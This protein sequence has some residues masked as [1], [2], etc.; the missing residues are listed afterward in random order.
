MATI[1]FVVPRF[2]TNLWF[3][4][5]ALLDAG[6]RVEIAAAGVAAG[7]D[8]SH[9]VPREIGP[10]PTA[11]ELADL[12]GRTDPDLAIVRAK[13]R[14][15]ERV[16]AA[17]RGCGVPVLRYD[18]RPVGRK[19]SF[20]R[21][22]RIAL[23]R[24]PR[25]RITPVPGLDG[26]ASPGRDAVYLPFPVAALPHSAIPDRGD[27]EE[28]RILAVGKLSQPRKNLPLLISA[29][30]D[31]ASTGRRFTLTIAGSS[32]L[33][34]SGASRADH[35][36][37]VAAARTTPWLDLRA[38]VPFASMPDLYAAH[39]VCVLP[40]VE[41]P[42]GS[43][44]LEGMAYGTIP[45]ISTKAGT[46]GL[47]DHGKTGLR[48]DVTQEGALR[49][50]MRRL[51]DDADLRAKLSAGARRYAETELS[52]ARYVARIEALLPRGR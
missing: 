1:L 30:R 15:R 51:L 22:L 13:G 14:V 46:A 26:G 39:D 47:I 9:V 7:E 49:D 35:A 27:G 25:R 6:H 2:H 10:D 31:L 17:A 50:A 34:A 4:A 45:V 24:W 44:P 38:D 28:V 42:L 33:L 40:S 36:E 29:L 41:E 20:R 23:G 48:V 12:F 16:F 5:R 8:H 32:T 43:A 37:L 19:E 21:R 11:D 3:A 18:Q 52:P